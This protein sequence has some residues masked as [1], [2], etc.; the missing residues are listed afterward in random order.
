MKEVQDPSDSAR[1]LRSRIFFII[2]SVISFI[3]LAW[4]LHGANLGRLGPEIVHLDWRWVA[5]GMVLD[6]LVFSWQAWRWILVLKPVSPVPV[7]DASVW[8]MSVC[9]STKWFRCARR[10]HP[11]LSFGALD[12]SADFAHIGIGVD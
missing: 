10:D 6:V 4:T 1:K 5:I 9:S 8:F 3:C 11:L 12:G 2:T 7:W